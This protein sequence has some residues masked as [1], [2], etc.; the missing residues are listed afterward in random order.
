MQELAWWP[1]SSLFTRMADALGC[2][3]L[4][5]GWCD[6]SS[7][8]LHLALSPSNLGTFGGGFLSG[9]TTLQQTWGYNHR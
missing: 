7:C 5:C 9:A 8:Q 3:N 4:P 6:I 1:G 2:T